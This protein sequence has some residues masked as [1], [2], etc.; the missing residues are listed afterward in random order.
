MR[1][2]AILLQIIQ[3]PPIF[4]PIFSDSDYTCMDIAVYDANEHRQRSD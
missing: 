4:Y 3:I 2:Y 1:C